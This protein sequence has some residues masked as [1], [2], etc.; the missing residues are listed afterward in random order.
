MP[1]YESMLRDLITPLVENKEAVMIRQLPG[2]SERDLVLLIVAEDKDT[3]R[4]IGRRGSVAN[5]LREVIGIAPKAHNERIHI[6]LKFE[7]FDDK[8]EETK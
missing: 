2:R 3:A 7:S 6:H 4:L 8:G 5:A 1:D